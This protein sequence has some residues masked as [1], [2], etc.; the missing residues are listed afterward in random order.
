M[1]DQYGAPTSAAL[2]TDVTAQ[3]IRQWQREGNNRFPFSL[4]HMVAGDETT[5]CEYVQFIVSEA[6]SAGRLLKLILDAIRGIPS[7]DYPTPT[8][9]PANSRLETS[10]LQ[11]AYDF[12][13]PHWQCGIRH[14]LQ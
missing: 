6:L 10:K 11:K 9:R 13:L 4:Y 2:L 8:K 1:A 3:L 14:V 7:S 12:E 5:W